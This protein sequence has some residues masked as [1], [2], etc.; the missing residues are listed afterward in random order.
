MDEL[1]GAKE[2]I[3]FYVN[4]GKVIVESPDPETTLLYFLRTQLRLTG[5]KLGCGE[6]GCGACTVMLSWCQGGLVTHAAVNACLAPLCSV[7]GMA[8]TTVEGIGSSRGILHPIQERIA[9]AHGSQCG[10]CTPGFVMSMYTLLRNTHA[11]S[12][13]QIEGAFKGNLCRCTG[14]RPI[15]EGFKTFSQ[16]GCC[17]GATKCC[18]DVK[19]TD[20]IKTIKGPSVLFDASKFRPLDPTQEPTFPPALRAEPLIP[21]AIKG[22]RVSWYRPLT[23][24]QLLV[25]RAKFPQSK[26]VIGNTEIG[27]E[28]KYKGAF[29]DTLISCSRVPELNKM[30]VTDEGLTVGA[31][32]TLSRLEKQLKHQVESLPEYK[33]R[34]FSALL[35]MLR[36][37]AGQ[38]IRNVSG[39]GGNICNA[40]PI[41]DLNP[42]LLAAGVKLTIATKDANRVIVI[43]P[44]FFTGYKKTAIKPGEILLSILIP[45]TKEYEFVLS[46]K[47]ARRRED[48]IAIVNAGLRVVLAPPAGD[49]DWTVEDC[50]LSYGG[51]SYITTVAKK[52]Q[53]YLIGKPWCESTLE[54]VCPLLLEDLPL[55]P[56]V[57]GGM[58]DY[59]RSLV[60][61]FF[62]KFYLTVLSR[63]R[64]EPLPQDLISA[65]RVFERPPVQ[66]CQGFQSVSDEQLPEDSVGRP[67]MHLSALQQASGE[68]RYMDDI[69]PTEGELYAGLVLSTHAHA[70]ITVDWSEAIKLPGVKGYVGVTDIP[71]SNATGPCLDE[72]V[73]ADGKVNLIG[74]IIGLIVAESQ[75]LAQRASKLVNVT[76]QDLSSV[77]S[78]EDAIAVESYYPTVLRLESGDVDSGFS[79]SDQCLE[80]MV[81]VGGQDHF[82][83]ETQGCRVVPKGENGEMEIV[84]STQGVEATQRCAARALDVP[85]NRIVAKVKRIG[86]GFGGKETRSCYLSTAVTVAAN[87]YQVPVRIMLD[88]NEDMISSGGRHPFLAKYKVGFTSTGRFTSIDFQF[89]SNAGYGQDLSIAVLEKILTHCDNAYNIPNFRAVARAC[90]THIA[91][92]TAF[93]GFGGP[94]GMIIM[95]QVVSH[96]ASVLSIPSEAV[97]ELNMYR[98]GDLTPWGQVQAQCSVRRCWDQLKPVFEERKSAAVEF[99]KTNRW[100]KRGVSL[101]PTKFGISFGVTFMSQGGALLHVYTDGSVLLTHGGMEMGQG[102]HTKM[103]QVCARCLGVPP[104]AVFISETSTDTVPNSIPTAASMSTD[105]YGMAVKDCCDQIMARLKPVMDEDPEGGWARWIQSAY[106]RRINLSVQG[107][108]AT[109]GLDFDW[110]KGRGNMFAYFSYGAA[111]AEVEVDTLTGDFTVLRTDIVMDVG[112]SIN[113]AI[114]IGQVEGAFTQGLGLVTL[115]Q[116]VYL[117]GNQRTQRGTTFTTG[118]G[119]YKIPSVS[120]VP[121]VFNVSLLDRTPNPRAIFSSKAVGEP[122]LFLAASVLFALREAITAARA[123]SGVSGY[124]RLDSPA[125]CERI[126]MACQDKFTQQVCVVVDP[127]AKSWTVEA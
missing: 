17:G 40:S 67:M 45:Y 55:P 6:G 116:C 91:P 94:Q 101:V 22:P 42:T 99:N 46:Y 71:G 14:Y 11:P 63:L 74:Q 70:N 82:Y 106:H 85:Y 124:Y 83:L 28:V 62:Y 51:M 122:P 10:F 43:Y 110:E 79:D 98:D 123:E 69:P 72:V 38:Q 102:L 35:E 109:P 118:P 104:E 92:N 59:R 13:K 88:R 57:P 66:S 44:S 127:S 61:S 25:L 21:L 84:S 65:T 115:E 96:V 58:P 100:C 76:Y 103:V 49:S 97:R 111:V 78:I 20:G 5:T 105:L 30:T 23:L 2:S 108:Y 56:D 95:E 50:C 18:M 27:V 7:D 126:R 90:R 33:T 1:E 89:Y 4:G 41:S 24:D 48:D 117:E 64:S 3:S 80:G 77:I 81:R 107:F 121:V 60:T 19:G 39:I 16:T 119:T 9:R 54:A 37:F 73:F 31:S 93:R 26:L 12:E 53:A 86:G 15:L 87:K 36:W 113:P 8:V 52:T 32:V 112:D 47:Q 120:D 68:A 34:T 114:D 125:T 29:Y 75:P